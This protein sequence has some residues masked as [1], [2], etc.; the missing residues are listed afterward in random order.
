M[1]RLALVLPLLLAG[2]GG[3][4]DLEPA[5]GQPLPATAYGADEPS[6]APRL[7]TLPPEAR[8]AAASE[9]LKRSEPRESDRFDLPPPD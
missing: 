3:R 4:G 6:T 1:K 8:P 9:L 7:L 5:A 2:C